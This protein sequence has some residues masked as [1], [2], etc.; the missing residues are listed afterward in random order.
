MH[1][2]GQSNMNRKHQHRSHSPVT[3]RSFLKT[4]ALITAGIASLSLSARAQVNKNSKLRILQIGVGGVGSMQRNGLKDH[5]MIEWA[6]FCDVDSR[7]L[8]SIKKQHPNAWTLADYREAFANKINDFD[9]VILDAPDF[10]HAP[11]MLTAMKHNKHIYGQKPLVHQLAELRMIRDGLKARPNLVTQM[12]NQRACNKGRMV[13][14]E[15]LRKNQLGRPVEAYVWTGGVSRGFYFTDPWSSY[16]EAKPVPDYLN[17]DLW[18]GPLT[19]DMP[20]S[21]DLAPRRWRAFW[22][23]G[24]GQLADWGCHLLDLLY[25]AYDLPSPEAVITHTPKPSNTGH[26]AHNQSTITYPGGGK[27]AREKFVVRYNDDALLPSFAALG[28][29]PMKPAANH[30]MVVCEEGTLLLQADGALK[31]FRKGQEVKDEPQPEVAPRNHWK[32]W[33]DNCLG[34]K[35]PLWTPFDIGWRITE[36]ALLAVKATRFPG[37]ELRWDAANF[38]FSNHDKANGEIVSRNYREG[39][40]PPAVS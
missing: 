27:F 13:S 5:P 30:T 2:G 8:E 15:I 4:G 20:Y 17:W 16:P 36:P 31:I 1:N 26:T 32:D 28:L 25:F 39:F 21:E 37:Q 34:D 12:G 35:K 38:K 14:V 40:A 3:R 18:R 6:G 29:P 24:G 19:G 10:H 22:E 11:V 33:A 7:Q 23:T 9:A